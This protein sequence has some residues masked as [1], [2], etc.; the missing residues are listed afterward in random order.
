LSLHGPS[1]HYYTLPMPDV[2][3]WMGWMFT[4]IGG[5]VA[6][7]QVIQERIRRAAR[8][9]HAR[10]LLATIDPLGITRAFFAEALA[11]GEVFKT[12][13]DKAVIRAVAHNLLAAENHIREAL[14]SEAG[15][16]RRLRLIRFGGHLSK[17]EYDVHTDGRD[18]Q[19]PAS[20]PTV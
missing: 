1:W 12:D 6:V 4:V 11:Q 3:G 18:D 20:P 16:P 9:A 19:K 13:A 14:G 2:L 8:D 17:G 7:W 5:G 10:H 15:G